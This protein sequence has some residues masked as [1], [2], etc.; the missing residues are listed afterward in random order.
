VKRVLL[1]ILIILLSILY[2][3]DTP[4]QVMK[5]DPIEKIKPLK[6]KIMGL[7]FYLQDRKDYKE[8]CPD[9]EWKQPKFRVYKR[10]PRSYLPEG[11]KEL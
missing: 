6:R 9:I 1:A 5:K 2:F 3:Q 4:A 10:D 11:C 7:E 8:F